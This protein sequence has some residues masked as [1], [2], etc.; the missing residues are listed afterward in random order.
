[1]L[2][3]GWDI[4]EAD[5]RQWN[6]EPG[7]HSIKNNSE[8]ERG[9]PVPAISRNETGFKQITVTLLVKWDRNRQAILDRCSTILSRLLEPAELVLDDF[10]HNYYGILSRYKFDENPLNV[11][12]V[13]YNRAAKLSLEFDCFEY[14]REETV[15]RFS[16][17]ADFVV[18][19][20]GNILTPAVIEITPQIGTAT[21]ELSGICRGSAGEDLPVTVRE[22]KTG[23]KVVLN[24]E[25]G[26]FTEAGEP[27]A[28]DTDIWAL[29]AL[30][31]GSNRI[32]VSSSRMDITVRFRP[33]FM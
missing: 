15:K 27:K 32:L 21:L 7:F 20:T 12:F 17:K 16:G 5:A 9:S 14:A 25:T 3:N 4:S 6:V 24:G 33:R 29:P 2:I 1:M 13:K 8:W 11:P 26:L 30:L 10:K 22:L 23:K 19:N 18:E 31:P 28:A